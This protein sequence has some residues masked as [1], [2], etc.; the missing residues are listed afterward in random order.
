[1]NADIFAKRQRNFVLWRVAPNTSPPRL[2]IGRLQAGAPARLADEQRFDLQQ[3]ADFSDLWLVPAGDCNL[4][5]G[6]VY[7]Y[8]FE[9][10]DAHPHRFGQRVSVTDPM[11]FTV[12]W[13]LLA[14]RPVGP[15]YSDDDRYPAAVVKFSQGR[16]IPCDAGGETGE[17]GP[18]ASLATLPPNNWLVLYELPTAWARIG[19]AGE[20]EIGV[21]TFRDVLALVDP[22]EAGASF[23]DLDVTQPGRSYLNEL[24]VNAIELLP[25]AD[26]FYRREWGY[27]TTNFC[28]PDFELGFPSDSSWPTPNRDLRALIAAS[29]EQGLRFFVDV[30]MAFARTNAYLAAGTNDFFILDPRADRT[31]PDAHNSRGTDDSNLRNGFGSTLFRYAALV[32]GYDPVSGGRADLSPARQL[33]KSSLLRWMND[34]H[35]DGIRVDSVEN[36]ANWDFLQE[37]KDLAREA[38]R[39]R[40]AAEAPG[41]GADE[42]FLVVGEELHEP[43]DLLR[44]HRLEGL[45]HEGFKRFIRAALLGQI[46]AGEPSFEWTVRKAIDCRHFGYSDGAEAIIYL[47]SHDVEGVRNERLFNFFRNNG[48]PDIPRR[49]KLA[50]VCLLTAVGIPMILAGDEFADEHDLF[51]AS[52]HVT[53]GGGKQVDPVNFSRLTDGWRDQL[54]QYVARLIKLRTANAGL[55]VNDTE[56]IH[57]DFSDEKRVLAWRRGRHDSEA[58][59]VVANFSDFGTADPLSPNAEYRVANWP[60]TPPGMKWREITQERDVPAEWIGREPIFPWEAKV[61]AVEPSA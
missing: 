2:M 17:L 25:P 56:F 41:P 3:S 36:V 34:F 28:A 59:V 61:Y 37:Y 54:K 13:R 23:S 8:W 47:T 38:W 7:H 46:A 55:A 50:F 57:R 31:D 53:Q 11:A 51:D 27:G 48:V 4:A 22:H 18:E 10:E 20:R 45:W 29:H 5:D 21:G 44:Q 40:F 35:I 60:A 52:G 39:H 33:M 32:N 15:A 1:M 14:P 9:I 6:F 30:V 43:L 24:G 16:L 42:R 26:S 58:V 49:C 19:S 12:D